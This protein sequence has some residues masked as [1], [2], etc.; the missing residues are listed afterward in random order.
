MEETFKWVSSLEITGGIRIFKQITGKKVKHFI[1]NANLYLKIVSSFCL[2]WFS[3]L[4][5]FFYTSVARQLTGIYFYNISYWPPP[6]LG[7]L[8]LVC[9]TGL[10]TGTA[11]GH[12]CQ[13]PLV[14]LSASHRAVQP[15]PRGLE[16][17]VLGGQDGG[18]WQPPC[19]GDGPSQAS[20]LPL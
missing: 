4:H 19:G 1:S 3:K 12:A 2:L 8:Q 6:A 17:R 7:F 15:Q 5:I 18:G 9:S 14:Q 16:P 11:D 10:W 13:V 20:K